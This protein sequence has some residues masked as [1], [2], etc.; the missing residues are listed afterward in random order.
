MIIREINTTNQNDSELGMPTAEQIRRERRQE[1]LKR[2]MA[3][4]LG[5]VLLGVF[6]TIYMYENPDDRVA[7]SRRSDL[8]LK[9]VQNTTLTPAIKANL[10]NLTSDL[11]QF[12]KS[13][14]GT[15]IGKWLTF[16]LFCI[17]GLLVFWNATKRLKLQHAHDADLRDEIPPRM[18]TS[19]YSQQQQ[20]NDEVQM[21]IP[22]T[23][24]EEDDNT[25]SNTNNQKIEKPGS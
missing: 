19:M 6:F 21:V 22:P 25:A 17:T 24:D 2:G 16:G 7:C 3:H 23:I 5:F 8:I 14:A 12:C 15:E 4:H 9:A 20:N 1:Q 13:N 18:L 11:S 10:N